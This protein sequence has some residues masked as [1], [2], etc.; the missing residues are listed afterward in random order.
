MIHLDHLH[1]LTAYDCFCGTLQFSSDQINPDSH[2]CQSLGV[3][4]CIGDKGSS[5]TCQIFQHQ[6]SGGSCVQINKI[7]RCDQAGCIFCDLLLFFFI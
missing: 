5:Y 6:A 7:I 1:C 4:Y 3:G 2:L